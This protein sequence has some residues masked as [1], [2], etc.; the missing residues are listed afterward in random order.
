V[1]ADRVHDSHPGARVAVEV[2]VGQRELGEHPQIGGVALLLP[3]QADEPHGSPLLDEDARGVGGRL[4]HCGSSGN[5][6]S[7][8]VGISG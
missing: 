3:V 4:R 7:G 8:P 5:G 1:L 6:I 2:A